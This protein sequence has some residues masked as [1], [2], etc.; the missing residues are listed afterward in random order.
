LPFQK[1]KQDEIDT[2]VRYLEEE[3]R[4]VKPCIIS[5]TKIDERRDRKLSMR[6]KLKSVEK[7]IAKQII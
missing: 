2:C 7:N 6:G 3:I 4:L 1:P 5:T